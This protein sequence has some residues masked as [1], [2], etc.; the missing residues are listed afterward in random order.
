[1]RQTRDE[2]S[3]GN[4]QAQLRGYC[5]VLHTADEGH[6]DWP[7]SALLFSWVHEEVSPSWLI[8]R[9]RSEKSTDVSVHA[10]LLQQ[11]GEVI[12]HDLRSSKTRRT[13]NN[14]TFTCWKERSTSQL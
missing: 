12:L 5:T 10:S 2:T 11:S 14:N 1:M 7:V 8:S 3:L 4:E 6:K 9:E 13:S